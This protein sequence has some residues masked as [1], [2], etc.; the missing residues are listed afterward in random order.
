M[1]KGI[2]APICRALFHDIFFCLF[3]KN[4]E[5]MKISKI[6]EPYNNTLSF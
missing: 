6:Y 2:K 1:A 4:I 3:V 5:H